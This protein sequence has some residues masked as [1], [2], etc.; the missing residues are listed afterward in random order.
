MEVG[1]PVGAVVV[2]VAF[3]DTSP[4]ADAVIFVDPTV[5]VDSKSATAYPFPAD[6]TIEEFSTNPTVDVEEVRKTVTSDTASVGDPDES[7]RD[8]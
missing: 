2:T 5:G 7:I 8:T 3:A 1:Y 4:E 6:I